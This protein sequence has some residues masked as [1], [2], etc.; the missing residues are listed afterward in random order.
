MDGELDTPSAAFDGI[1]PKMV[2]TPEGEI[3]YHSAEHDLVYNTK[4][5]G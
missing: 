1:D 2:M 3:V 4:Q 5:E